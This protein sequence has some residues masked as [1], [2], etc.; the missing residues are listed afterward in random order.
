MWSSSAWCSQCKVG[1]TFAVSVPSL[2]KSKQKKYNPLKK[3]LFLL[4]FNIYYKV[5]VAENSI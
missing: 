3:Q 1:A 2:L 4:S 5:Q